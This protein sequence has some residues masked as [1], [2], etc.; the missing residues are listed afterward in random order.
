ML[1][2][3]CKIL[4]T[5]LFE[6]LTAPAISRI[7]NLSAPFTRSWFSILISGVP[8]SSVYPLQKFWNPSWVILFEGASSYSAKAIHC[9]AG[10]I[11]STHRIPF[12]PF[13]RK[14]SSYTIQLVT[15]NDFDIYQCCHLS[16]FSWTFQSTVVSCSLNFVRVLCSVLVYQTLNKIL[17]FFNTRNFY[18][19]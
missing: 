2:Y 16:E 14:N 1:K 18:Y 12:Q 7:I 3:P 15:E 6:R 13:L 17:F 11:L 10:N 8:A 4:C 9:S 19:V 5:C